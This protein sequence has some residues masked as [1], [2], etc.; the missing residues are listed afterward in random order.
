MLDGKKLLIT[1]VVTRDSIAFEV[2]EPGPGGRRRG[3]ADRVRPRQ[4]DHRARGEAARRGRPTC[5]SSTSTAPRTSRRWPPTLQE[6][7]GRVDGV[8][9]AIAFAPE[10][11]LGGQL[12]QHAARERRG[13]VPD[14]RVLAEGA[15]RGA[16]RLLTRRAASVVGLDFDAS[17]AWPV[18]DW[19]GVAKAALEAVSRY[20]ARD[21][22][23]RGVRVNLVSAGPARHDR[24]ARHPRASSDL[25]D[26]VAA[27]G[28]ARLGHRR[29][30]A[31]RRRDLLPAHRPRPAA[32]TGE[33]LHVDGGF[34]AMGAA[35]RPSSAE[36]AAHEPPRLPHRRD[37]L[38]RHGGARPPA[39]APGPRGASRSSARATT[40]PPR[41]ASTTCSARCGATRRPTASACARW[42]ATS[43]SPGLGSRTGE[44]D[45]AGRGVD[46]VLHCAASISF[47]LPLDE[48]R[49]INVEGT[50]R[51]IDLAREAAR[52]SSAS[53]TSRPPTWP[54]RTG[55]LPRA[56]A[57]RGP[58]LPQHL[59]ADQ[60]GG[61]APRARGRRP[62][63]VHRA[64]EHRRG[65]VRHRLDARL[66]RRSTGRC[67]RS[68]AGCSTRSRATA[69]RP[70]R[71][72]PGR[73]R[74]RR[75]RAPARRATRTASST[76]SPATRRCAPTSSS[77]SPATTSTARARPSSPGGGR[78][79]STA[80]STCPT[81]TWTSSSTTPAR[82]GCW[83]PPASARRCSRVLRDG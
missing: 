12:P 57:R 36:E 56:P 6:R 1:G 48:A 69:E 18:Y 81:S 25:G 9:H 40:R 79:T 35:R 34:H 14:Q 38:P 77:T 16:R 59:R 60:V 83:S 72:R 26:G 66:Q 75:H 82:A 17:V 13:G 15:G 8:L 24:R 32:I 76:S 74:R 41:T 10:D 54:A 30:G 27:A 29:S 19:M 2:A 70:H 39:R 61:R 21:L 11:A 65:R 5:S 3:R 33:I 50:R 46:A 7:W 58:G 78:A 47:D 68:R 62:A 63:A 42:P 67:G 49:A 80:P 4:A 71:R 23:P 31:G 52:R 28:A 20:L 51:V 44:R 22:G 73:L 45:G 37:R 64:P 53:C 43:R 55:A